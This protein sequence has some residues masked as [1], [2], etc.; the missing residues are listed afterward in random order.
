MQVDNLRENYPKLLL[1]ME[2]SGYSTDY[3]YRFQKEIQWILSEAG[4]RDWECYEDVYRYYE[5]ILNSSETLESK[6]AIIGA[7]EQFDLYG[8]CPDSKWNGFAK[9][10]NAY[11][12]LTP[13]FRVLIDYY[14]KEETERGI[15]AT[16]IK[17]TSNGAA[18]FLYAMQE[19]GFNQL[20]EITED[21]VMAIFVSREG[22]LLKSYTYR[23]FVTSV[24]KACISIEPDA[25]QTI[26]SF[27]PR[28]KRTRKNI[29]YLTERESK[30]ICD[31][32]GDTSNTLTKC[33]RAI[34]KLAMYTGLRS[35][36]IAAMDITSIDWEKDLI[37]VNQQKTGNQFTLPLT[38]IVGNAIY[39]YLV[40]ERP[41]SQDPA[42]FL[43]LK[44][45]IR[46]ISPGNMWNVSARIM[47]AAGV[48]QGEGDRK[49]FHIFRHRLATTLLGNE[50]SQVVISRTLGHSSP[51]S[52]EM[53][54][55][56]DFVHLKECAL[57]IS[58][59]PVS[60]EVFN[61]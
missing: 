26:L 41:P 7:I 6:H 23:R 28:Q 24:L 14:I 22:K 37:R 60:K 38:A 12:R 47:K 33:D 43:T 53:Y 18:N 17:A 42:L 44:G 2:S 55:S 21:A 56:A 51:S 15:K 10:R 45:S 32:L 11:S 50:I 46:R 49:G 4:T 27:L 59:F 13:T 25:C 34:G 29:Q 5:T 61:D 58:C 54:L 31:S 30:K 57:N 3:I 52:T 9:N 39:E 16:T 40:D 1:Q 36:D 19:A 8:K 35:S 48:R 20:E